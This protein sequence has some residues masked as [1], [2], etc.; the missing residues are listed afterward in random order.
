MWRNVQLLLLLVSRLKGGRGRRGG[1]GEG[2]GGRGG[3]GGCL[4]YFVENTLAEV[5]FVSKVIFSVY[6]YCLT[7][8]IADGIVTSCTFY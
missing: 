4:C 2:E 5:V 7:I 8:N 6:C 1:K 3:R